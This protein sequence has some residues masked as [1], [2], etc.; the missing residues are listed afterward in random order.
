MTRFFIQFVILSLVALPC[1][2]YAISSNDDAY[3]FRIIFVL[4][5]WSIYYLLQDISKQDEKRWGHLCP[6][7]SNSE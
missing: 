5:L 7:L 2:G 3:C 1:F 4:V 6:Y